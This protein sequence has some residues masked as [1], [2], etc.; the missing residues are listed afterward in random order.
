M[1]RRFKYMLEAVLL[2]IISSSVK[3]IKSTLSNF[4]LIANVHIF[5]AANIK[6]HVFLFA[7]LAQVVDIKEPLRKPESQIII[8][9]TVKKSICALDSISTCRMP[10]IMILLNQTW[11]IVYKDWIYV[12]FGNAV[13]IILL[14]YFFGNACSVK[15]SP[16]AF[17]WHVYSVL[18]I[19]ICFHLDQGSTG[20]LCWEEWISPS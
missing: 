1:W 10:D 13:Y 7:A 17:P 11:L 2:V 16:K 6:C 3:V 19:L 9:S 14:H 4:T 12:I 18:S 5:H 20:S 15:N 8:H